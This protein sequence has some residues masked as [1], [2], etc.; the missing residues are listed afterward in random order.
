MTTSASRLVGTTGWLA[1]ELISGCGPSKESDIC[2]Y[3]C[4]YYK[5]SPNVVQGKHSP[6][7]QGP[8]ILHRRH[9]AVMDREAIQIQKELK[10]GQ[11]LTQLRVA[12]VQLWVMMLRNSLI[13]F[14]ERSTIYQILGCAGGCAATA[15]ETD[16][17]V[18]GRR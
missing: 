13:V 3:E 14:I 18:L 17:E 15:T 6:R 16:I 12:R 11:S 1:P 7:P 8:F 9:W 5:Q 10:H 2:A 4:V